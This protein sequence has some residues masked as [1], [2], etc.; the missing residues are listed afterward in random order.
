MGARL[1]VELFIENGSDERVGATGIPGV[2]DLRAR[3]GY[4]V[5]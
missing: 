5:H 3:T 1:P 2:T 4:V